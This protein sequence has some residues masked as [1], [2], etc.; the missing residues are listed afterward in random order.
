MQSRPFIALG[1]FLASASCA[2][3]AA[4]VQVTAPNGGECLIAGGTYTV[5]WQGE[6]SSHYALSGGSDPLYAPTSGTWF[7]DT[8]YGNTYNWRVPT[9]TSNGSVMWVEAHD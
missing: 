8:V 1:I 9:S 2:F 7:A 4:N 5:V 3:A 6:T